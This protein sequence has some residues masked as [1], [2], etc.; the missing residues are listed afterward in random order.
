MPIQKTEWPALFTPEVVPRAPSSD[1][2]SSICIALEAWRRGLAITF[3]SGN[4]HFYTIGDGCSEVRFNCALPTSITSR[5]DEMRLRRK[6]V[7]AEMLEAEG[8]PVPRTVAFS[9][10]DVTEQEIR[11][12]IDA[13]GFPL[14]VKPNMGSVGRGVF[15]DL[16]NWDEVQS[17]LRFLENTGTD[18]VIMQSHHFGDDIRVLVVGNR[19]VGAVRRIPAN[20]VGDGAK[21]VSQ[22]IK[23]K[24]YARRRNPFLSKGLIRVD[25]EVERCLVEQQVTAESV[26]SEG[27]HVYLRKVANASAG[28]DVIDITDDLP[29]AIK[30]AAV[31]AVGVMPNIVISGVDVIHDAA[32]GKF[33]IIEMNRRPHIALNM[34]PTV[35]LGRDVPKAIVDFFF[36]NSC[37]GND[38]DYGL[39][40]FNPAPIRRLLL[41]RAS[42]AVSVSPLPRHR[43]R[44]R[45]LYTLE[46]LEEG[47]LTRRQENLILRAAA[48]NRVA[49]EVRRGDHCVELLVAG[50][51]ELSL[52]RVLEDVKGILEVDETDASDWE[53]VLTQGFF[54][55]PS[56]VEGQR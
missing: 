9:M 44:F 4:L 33:V 48:R 40:R 43:F 6:R 18:E 47:R 21:S 35:G 13:I 54:V 15:V 20:V 51:R 17:S 32:S 14:V 37:R 25:H 24:N 8:L 3:H 45:R 52:Q 29:S 16:Q 27:R 38:V 23:E 26:P 36:P 34:Y 22:L 28:G 1:A 56:L 46:G 11:N 19:V 30:S 41:S 49:G 50:A 31:D 10:R 53:G 2:L 39:L 7:A 12:Y 55:D 5:E 42:D